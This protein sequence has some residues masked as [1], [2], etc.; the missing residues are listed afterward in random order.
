M[1]NFKVNKFSWRRAE[2]ETLRPHT[3]FSSEPT[4]PQKNCIRG[5]KYKFTTVI[6]PWTNL[7]I[8]FVDFF[9]LMN[10]WHT[11]LRHLRKLTWN[12]DFKN[13]PFWQKYTWPYFVMVRFYL[14]LMVHNRR[15]YFNN[16]W[17]TA[18]LHKVKPYY[19]L[20]LLTSYI[21]IYFYFYIAFWVSHTHTKVDLSFPLLEELK[22]Q[23]STCTQ[24]TN[25]QEMHLNSIWKGIVGAFSFG[26]GFTYF[27]SLVKSGCE[28]KGWMT[29]LAK[30]LHE[31][32]KDVSVLD[33]GGKPWELFRV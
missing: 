23:A 9:N 28:A 16:I 32:R 30:N 7:K 19:D 15:V 3:G 14:F 8:G 10:V 4:L 12:T 25:Q 24:E 6:S 11:V 29:I 33:V 2:Y 20:C 22:F 17:L 13:T 21:S 1:G 26:E 18:W 5:C 31:E 27:I